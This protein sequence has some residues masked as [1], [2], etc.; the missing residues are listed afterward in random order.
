M[1]KGRK[2]HRWTAEEDA[3]LE[4]LSFEM[5]RDEIADAMGMRRGQVIGRI[6]KL[7]N[8]G[9]WHGT[10]YEKVKVKTN[11][12]R[13]TGCDMDCERC[14]Y[15]DCI[16]PYSVVKVGLDVEKYIKGDCR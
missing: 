10:G 13:Y 15:S 14:P 9:R 3:K 8:E 5:T 7:R 1:G 12:E 16:A 11:T 6:A 4:E 2:L